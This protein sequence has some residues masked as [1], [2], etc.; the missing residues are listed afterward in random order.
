MDLRQ[1]PVDHV[2]DQ[3]EQRLGTR[4]DRTSVVRKR[5]TV[6]ASTDRGSWTRVERRPW[7]RAREQGW[8]GFEAAAVLAGVAM[9]R[10][11]GS[12]TWQDPDDRAI[13]HVDETSLL[14]ELPVGAAVVTV[15]PEL[16]DDWW[17]SL[18]ASL[19][20]LAV[21]RTARVAAPD[22]ERITQQLV[23][24]T[25]KAAFRGAH[26]TRVEQWCPAHADL[27]WANVTGPGEFCM[28]DWEDWGMAPRG[29]D[30]ASLY[31]A[32]LAV[33]A[34]ADRVRRE[35]RADL[36]SRD[37]VVMQLFVLAKIAGPHA[38]PNDPRTGPAHR[39]AARLI[40]AL[41]GD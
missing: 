3:V 22:T 38:G 32:S 36:E 19:A 8:G 28:F 29:L 40:H 25:I 15:D 9:P 30:S 33:P 1:E 7:A 16:P 39:E 27:N 31:A 12:A 2:L 5:R 37:G 6:G 17:R 11:S 21:Q 24:N 4:L 23:D 13:W 26:D 34:L 20:V 41:Q 14:P 35:R 18:N 10:W